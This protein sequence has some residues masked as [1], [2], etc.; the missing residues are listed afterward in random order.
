M[1]FA[2]F[3]GRF[4]PKLG[5]C[6]RARPF[7]FLAPALVAVNRAHSEVSA[8]SEFEDLVFWQPTDSVL[9]RTHCDLARRA[10]RTVG[11]SIQMPQPDFVEIHAA[12]DVAAANPRIQRF[13]HYTQACRRNGSL[14]LRAHFD[15]VDVPDLLPNIWIVEAD[16]DNARLSYRLAGTTI[17]AGMGFEPTGRCMTEIMGERLRENPQLLDRYWFS[18]TAGIATWRRGPARFWQKMDYIEIEN[19]IVPFAV[20]DSRVR[21]LMGMSIHYRGDGT[22]F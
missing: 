2:P 11:P 9:Y 4:L 7:L 5:P 10:L 3:R 19:L 13:W 12:A 15:P 18:A 22:A 20:A 6:L 14:P 17:V 8:R 16:S 21:H 1:A